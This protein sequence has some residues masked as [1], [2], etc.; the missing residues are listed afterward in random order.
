MPNQTTTQCVLFPELFD[1]P[2]VTRFDLANGSSDGGAVLRKAVDDRLGLIDELSKCLDDRRMP[3]K[4][5]HGIVALLS[6][7]V[8]GIACGYA[9]CNDAARL[10]HDPVHRLLVDRD[11]IEGDP[12]ASQPTLSRFENTVR[13][14]DLYRMGEA[15]ASTVIDRH[16]LRL[17][18]KCRLAVVVEDRIAERVEG[19]H[20]P[21]DDELVDEQVVEAHAGSI[22]EWIRML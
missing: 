9:D 15:L 4:I 13:P 8:F 16:R 20:H 6:Q 19:G 17:G 5:E 18:R 1:R 11:P 14:R 10:A 22:A 12:L 21:V 3:G 7:R 2:L